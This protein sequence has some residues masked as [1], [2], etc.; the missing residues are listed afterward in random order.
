[1]GLLGALAAAALRRI[2]RTAVS[3]IRSGLTSLGTLTAKCSA[4]LIGV[5]GLANSMH[6]PDDK[7][8]V[9]KL[10]EAKESFCTKPATLVA[11]MQLPPE[12][13]PEDKKS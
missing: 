12:P 2:K 5:V 13:K 1:M 10:L 6:E 3:V 9:A 4:G 7:H 8:A 11:A